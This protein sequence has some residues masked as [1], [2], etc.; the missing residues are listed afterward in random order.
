MENM[1]LEDI[2]ELLCRL[3]GNVRLVISRHFSKSHDSLDEE[4][5]CSDNEV[6][7]GDQESINEDVLSTSMSMSTSNTNSKEDT[8]NQVYKNLENSDFKIYQEHQMN[9]Q[10]ANYT[11]DKGSVYSNKNKLIHDNPMGNGKRTSAQRQT[12]Q[13]NDKNNFDCISIKKS[14][15]NDLLLE[16]GVYISAT[17]KQINSISEHSSGSRSHYQNM[18]AIGDRILSINGISLTNKNLYE[19]MDLVNQCKSFNLV[20]QKITPASQN[21]IAKT[22]HDSASS[23]LTVYHL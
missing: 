14:S 1:S 13:Q 18:L 11:Q 6:A 20:I 10:Y 4:N 7:T 19:I 5:N 2:H 16:T 15:L 22:I 9:R 8:Q 23:I 17:T 21:L 12:N 3:K